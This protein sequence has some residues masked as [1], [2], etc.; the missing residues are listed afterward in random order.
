MYSYGILNFLHSQKLELETK[1]K[2]SEQQNYHL[3]VHY[4]EAQTGLQLCK[5]Q[6]ANQHNELDTLQ[7]KVHVH[8]ETILA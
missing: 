2:E 5:L 7:H 6:L 1:L 4:K 3:N 8:V